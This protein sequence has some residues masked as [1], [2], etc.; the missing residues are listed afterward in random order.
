MNGLKNIGFYVAPNDVKITPLLIPENIELVELITAGEVFFDVDGEEKSLGKGTIFW[1]KAGENTICRTTVDSP[2]QCAVFTFFVSDGNRPVPRVS[3]WNNDTE[4]DRFAAECLS[5]FHSK[6]LDRDVLSLY[7]YSTLLRQAV[8]SDNLFNRKNYPASIERALAYIH[9]RL[10]KKISIEILARNSGVSQPHLFKLF[11]AHLSCT[12]HQYI[13]SQQLLRART[14]LA[15]TSMPIKMIAGECGFENLE[16]FY[17]RF[18][19]EN[20]MPPGEYRSKH[21]PYRFSQNS[22]F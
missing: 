6:K 5:L 11:G 17:R 21:M 12:P 18:G 4:I 15:G 16:V 8:V 7:V 19:R 10:S 9:N 13:L 14:M 22:T 1:H 2:Y 3:F 20:G